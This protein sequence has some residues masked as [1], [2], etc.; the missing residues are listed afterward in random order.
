MSKESRQGWGQ[1]TRGDWRKMQ[2]TEGE[3]LGA[4]FHRRGAGYRAGTILCIGP[5]HTRHVHRRSTSKC[6]R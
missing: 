2:L 4:G 1:G 6:A 5:R 3:T